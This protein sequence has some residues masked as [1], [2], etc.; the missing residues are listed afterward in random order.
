[1]EDL[2]DW[3]VGGDAFEVARWQGFEFEG[4]SLTSVLGVNLE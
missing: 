2:K 3:K 4:D 1:M